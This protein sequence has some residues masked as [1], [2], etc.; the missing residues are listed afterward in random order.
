MRITRSKDLLER[1]DWTPFFQ[2]W[3]LA[4]RFPS[5]L[6][7]APAGAAARTLYEDAQTMLERIVGE[8]WLTARAV[9]GFYPANSAGD[10]DIEVYTD[11]R[12][13]VLM[14]LHCIRQKWLVTR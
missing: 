4:G 8:N 2:T 3:E 10:D 7:D 5:I 6:E 12:S 9:V 11:D 1:I 14:T 13:T